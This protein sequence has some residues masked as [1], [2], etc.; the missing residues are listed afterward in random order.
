M[1]KTKISVELNHEHEI[2]Q[3]K[4]RYET[5]ILE[6]KGLKII[7]EE[8]KKKGIDLVRELEGLADI[9]DKKL[10]EIVKPLK[11][12]T[13]FWENLIKPFSKSLIELAGK[14]SY[15]GLRGQLSDYETKQSEA[16][17]IEE[18]KIRK[19]QQD[20]Y[21]KEVKKAE[22]K[23]AIPPPPP[24]PVEVK[25]SKEEGVSYRDDYSFDENGVQI[26][27]VPE[28]FNGVRLKILD[29][30]TVQKL[31]DAGTRE[32]PGIP[33]TFKRVPIIRSEKIEDL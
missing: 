1:Q 27:K 3:L 16:R 29:K 30:K 32:I 20:A 6:A 11:D 2:A 17:R 18:E 14:D 13:K 23:G 24:P 25:E 5:L 28:I 22:K 10:K 26:D 19:E 4:P 15:E 33:I 7:D 31:I 9:F 21:N 8:T 12:H